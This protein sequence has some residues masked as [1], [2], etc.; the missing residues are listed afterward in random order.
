VT[1][2]DVGTLANYVKGLRNVSDA[3]FREGGRAG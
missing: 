2:G 3:A 1:W